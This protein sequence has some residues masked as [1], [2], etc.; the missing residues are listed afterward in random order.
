MAENH[1]RQ[2]L[3]SGEF[4]CTAELVLG[5][6]YNLTEAEEFVKDAAAE[7]QGMKVIS[8]TDLPGGNPAVPPEAF[9]SFVLEQNLTPL[10]HLTA[11]DSNRGLL[12]GRLYSLSRMG[13]ENVLVLSGDAP[14][15]GFEGKPKPVYDLDSV[16]IVRLIDALKEGIPYKVGK[17]TLQTPPF[18]F[19][20]GSVVNPFKV[21]EPALMTQLYKLE[22]KIRCGTQFIITQLGYNLRKMYEMQ[23]YMMQ[24]GLGHIPIIANVYVP[25]ATIAKFM[26]SGEVPGCVISDAFIAKLKEEKKPQRLER[27][28]IMVAAAKGLGF[29]GAHIGGFAL[30]HKDFMTIVER[31]EEIGDQ[32]REHMDELVFEFG[33]DD[34][35]LYPKASNGL[36]DSTQPMQAPRTQEPG[37][38]P[39]KLFGLI[40]ASVVA[41]ISPFGKYFSWRMKSLRKKYDDK[42]ERGLT[43]R[44]LDTADIVKHTMLECVNCGDCM[45]DYMGFS[46][47]SMGK[48]IKETRNGPCGGGR[49]DG[50]C[51]VKPEMQCVWNASYRDLLAKGEDPSKFA[52][53]LIPSRRWDL[54]R[55]NSLANYFAEVDSNLL[56][57]TVELKA[58]P[59]EPKPAA[60]KDS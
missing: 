16:Q 41:D 18:N 54:D 13:A 5:R 53:T 33:S 23:Q 59:E 11:K 51:E 29:A 57:R 30:K 46:G 7:P 45:Q 14:V 25:T 34:F 44:L 15:S 6:D 2:S 9:A 55:T 47:C 24:R 36:S 28:A 12:E 27:A 17:R 8:I 52:T 26:Q 39:S 21:K 56:R 50:T 20:V 38:F 48:C 35:Y 22:L 4:I 3:E 49:V 60:E 58:L 1:L 37:S 43:Y 40:H 19:Q 10:V 42:W 31:A 32:W